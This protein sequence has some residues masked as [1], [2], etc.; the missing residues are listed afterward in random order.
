MDA[1]KISTFTKKLLNV[2]RKMK[3]K[4]RNFI[5]F[6]EENGNLLNLCVCVCA[7]ATFK[8]RSVQNRIE[9]QAPQQQNVYDRPTTTMSMT[10]LPL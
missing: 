9:T 1:R 8:T 10:I 3:S 6:H 4:K 7:K 5:L 2:V